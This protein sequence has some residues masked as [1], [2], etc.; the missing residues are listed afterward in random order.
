MSSRIRRERHTVEVMIGM[1][2]RGHHQPPTSVAQGETV[3]RPGVTL[4]GECSL[5]LAYTLHKID[6]CRFGERKPACVRCTVHCFRP[7]MREQIR[8]VMR[9]SG[10]RMTYRHPY[11]ALRHVFDRR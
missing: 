3:G 4:C 7:D 6:A 9:Y 8:V 2:C 5:L 11:L 1:Y 10:P